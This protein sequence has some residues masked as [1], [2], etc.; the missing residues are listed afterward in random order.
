[1][2]SM[3]Y[4]V[5]LWDW[6]GTLLD[7]AEFGV[8]I[9]NGLLRS[10]GLPERSRE[11]HGRLFDFPVIRYYERLGFD[12]GKEP[13]EDIS[14]DFVASYY[15]S[16]HECPLHEGTR[17]I[18]Q[19]FQRAGYRQVILSATRQDLLENILKVHGL[20]PFFESILGIDSVHAPGKSGR[21]CDWIRESGV[22]PA[23]V[24]LIGDTMHDAEVAEKMGTDCWLIN[25]GHHPED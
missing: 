12:F 16:V 1:M 25:S 14:H 9:V 15:G 23:R 10:R 6:N 5:I 22:D 13:F 19:S 21:G 24:L 8:R 3:P 20:D 18:L 17:Q 11:D 2:E 7:D 4:D